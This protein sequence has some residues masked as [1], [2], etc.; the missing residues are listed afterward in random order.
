MREIHRRAHGLVDLGQL[1]E[2]VVQCGVVEEG[3]L[4]G[5]HRHGGWRKIADRQVRR[6]DQLSM[7]SQADLSSCGLTAVRALSWRG[8]AAVA[9]GGAMRARRHA[10]PADRS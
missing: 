10:L 5:S 3:D 1:S 4:R 9:D 7:T 8:F 2:E 6:W